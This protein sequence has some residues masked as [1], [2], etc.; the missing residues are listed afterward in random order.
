MTIS[1]SKAQIER[2]PAPYKA[3]LAISS[4][5][6]ETPDFNHYLELIKFIASDKPTASTKGLNLEFANSIYFDMPEGSFSY[7]NVSGKE[8]EIIRILIRS[9]YV[10]TIHSFG[11]LTTTRKQIEHT[12]NELNKHNCQLAVWS[13]HRKVPTNLGRDI[14]AGTG[15]IPTSET[16]HFDLTSAIGVKYLWRGRVTSVIGQD[17]PLDYAG[18]FNRSYPL[19]SARTIIKE[20]TKRLLATLGN[21][22]Y[23]MHKHNQLIRKITLRDNRNA[24]EF[25]RFNPHWAGV[26]SA[27]TAYQIDQVITKNMLDTL[28]RRKAIGIL[29]THLGKIGSYK[30]AVTP[31]IINA[32]ELLADYYHRNELLVTTPAKLLRYVST[33]DQL[34]F[35]TQLQNNKLTITIDSIDDPIAG[36]RMPE[37]CELQGITFSIAGNIEQT[38]VKLTTG[39]ALPTKTY[40]KNNG[41]KTLIAVE[42][43]K[44]EFPDV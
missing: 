20:K 39:E 9:G 15:D 1:Q 33:R 10:D 22:K 11:E 13:D 16:Y 29:Y 34:I 30:S 42:W 26:S 18:I 21:K 25:I 27:D 5:L 7:R 36:V 38:E 32:F 3:M 17:V 19:T 8:R 35:N 31:Q 41:N 44:L 12:I 14:T 6:D 40:T 43:N 24:Y 28:I 4:D 37:Y 23:A 2:I